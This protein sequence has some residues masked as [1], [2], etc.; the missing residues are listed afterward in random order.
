M[1]RISDTDRA[2]NAAA[3][4]AAMDRLLRGELP[5]GGRCDLKTLAAEAGVTRNGFYPKKDRDG[6]VREGP[7]QHLGDE[8]VRRLA[9]LREA[10]EAPDPRDAQIERLRAQ[11]AELED[12]LADRDKSIEEL[13]AFKKLA[14][15]RLAAQHDEIMHLRSPRPSPEPTPPAK[16]TTVPRARTTIVGACS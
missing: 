2:R 5:P 12:R 11:N 6:S 15:S 10:G 4:R 3:I 14:L 9:A 1:G 13:T 7:Y 16:L 8:F